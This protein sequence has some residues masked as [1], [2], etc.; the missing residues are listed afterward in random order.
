MQSIPSLEILDLSRNN[1]ATIA[2]NT[3]INSQS[4]RHLDL[5]VNVLRAVS[6]LFSGTIFAVLFVN[7]TVSFEY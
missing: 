5:S 2:D 4:L 7:L 1:I 3:F 6:F